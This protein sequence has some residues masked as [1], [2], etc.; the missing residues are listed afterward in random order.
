[1]TSNESKSPAVDKAA[2]LFFKKNTEIQQ[3]S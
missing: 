3:S 1:M 2:D